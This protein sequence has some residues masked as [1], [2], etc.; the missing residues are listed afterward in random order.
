[1]RP[2]IVD[3]GRDYRGGQ[4]QALL[5]LQGLRERGHT[6]ELIAVR[7][8]T[9]AVRAADIGAPVHPVGLTRRRMNAAWLVRRFVRGGG[10][11][12]V[13]AN[14]PHALTAAWL[15]RAHRFVP[16]VA[17][18]RVTLPLARG[19]FSLARYRAAA[20][21]I[22]VSEFVKQTVLQSGLAPG[23]VAVIFDGVQIPPEISVSERHSARTQCGISPE[24]RVVG[25]IAAFVPQK[26]HAFLLEAFARVIPQFPGGVFLARGEGP[27]LPR[28]QAR[29]RELQ[30]VDSVKFLTPDIPIHTA[31]AAMDVF[32]FPATGEAL[33]SALL[34]AMAQALPVAAIDSGGVS[35]VVENG[36][37]GVTL[38]NPD[39]SA[40]GQALAQLL[41]QPDDAGRLGKAARETVVKDFSADRMVD[42]TLNLYEQ[43]M[44]TSTG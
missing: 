16:M 42:E 37:N 11:D 36:K 38:K 44:Q 23:R 8:S 33:G 32:A 20:R 40:F 22:A 1:V 30:I 34:A 19:Y 35:E 7:N 31:F 5:L 39:P 27:E 12:L 21:I 9:L 15:A 3:L 17:S 13:H 29:T 25:Y 26:R 18:R 4:H 43:L 41:S 6:P 28:L 2:L 10:V 24:A 14:E